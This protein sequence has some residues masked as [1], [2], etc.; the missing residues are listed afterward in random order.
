V[1]G[2]VSFE[3]KLLLDELLNVLK[4]KDYIFLSRY[5]KLSANEFGELR[6]KVEKASDRS[7]V[8]KNTLIRR[9]LNEIGIKEADGMVKGSLFVSVTEKDP[10]ILS[11]ILVDFAKGNE[12]FSLAGAC[13][14]GKACSASYL[15]QLAKLPSRQVLIAS[16]V[17][18]LNAPIAGFVNVL[19]QLTRSLVTALDQVQKK[20]AGQAS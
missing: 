12:N 19:G 17:G 15:E 14:E 9:A 7:V 11:K 2:T 20:K 1:Q 18:G 13:V 6:R 4:G 5:S 3:K 8:A 16:V 10:Q